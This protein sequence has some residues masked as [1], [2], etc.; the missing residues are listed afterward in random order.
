M[1]HPTPSPGH[2]LE[3][4]AALLTELGLVFI[5]LSLLARFALRMGLTPIPFYLVAGVCF[6][7]GGFRDLPLIDDFFKTGS[8]IGVIMLLF[9]LGLEYSGSE[10]SEGLKRGTKNGLLDAA[11]N[12]T[13][14]FLFGLLLK[15][16]IVSAILLGGVTWITAS[17]IVSKVL[18]DLD[19]LGNRETP[20]VLSILV[21]EDLAMAV[22][23]PLVAVLL[24]GLGFLQGAVSI[25]IAL[26]TVSVV[27]LV[28]LRYGDKLS[29]AISHVSN[30][31]LLLSTFGIVLL[32]AGVAQKL[33]VSAAI[34]AF[35][36][37]LALEG[38]IAERARELFSPL[39]DLFAAT[40]F[41]F[42]GL[43]IDPSMLPPVLGIA[44]LLAIITA[45]TKFTT[46]W[47]SAKNDGAAE[48]GRMR[49]GLSLIARGEFS[50]VIAGLG[51]AAEPRLAPLSAAYVLI[52]AIAG[53]ILTRYSENFSDILESF[54]ARL[55][56][57]LDDL[58]LEEG[59]SLD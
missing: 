31:V 58:M 12:F 40:F 11:L 10:L 53:P 23:L 32:V 48:R 55:T 1:P 59:I 22:Y 21:I 33:Q 7:V 47:I 5:G 20:T 39:Q 15:W 24:L 56:P 54:Q 6:G 42:V 38:K 41:F 35:L 3:H 46:G 13:P 34:G 57:P 25:G 50:I 8:E 17:S 19:R 18:G 30:E 36:T 28:A 2:S 16:P 37:G 52:L 49:A 45:I 44:I 27:L 51:A 26:I 4:L 14:G 9:M 29:K 43:Q